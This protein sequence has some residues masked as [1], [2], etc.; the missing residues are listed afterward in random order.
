MFA[1]KSLIISFIVGSLTLSAQVGH[2]Q[3]ASKITPDQY[4]AWNISIFADGKNLPQGEGS[5]EEGA[6]LFAQECASCHGN[7]GHGGIKLDPYRNPI[8]TLVNDSS[9]G[10]LKASK[11]QKNIGT[12]WQYAPLLFDYIRRTM[13]YQSPKSLTDD[14]VYALSA[15]L[16]TQNKIITKTTRINNKN[17]A[18]VQM[19]NV[20]GFICD[21]H[22]DTVGSTCMKDCP[23]PNDA[24][25]NKNLIVDEKDYL[26]KDCLI[27]PKLKFLGL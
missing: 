2:Y 7:E 23:L 12:Y 13:P 11:P 16:L 15:Y 3:L 18:K 19:P 20:D 26:K 6:K 5:Y 1:S 14:E 25:F 4:K 21:N 24:T 22:V 8:A 10:G 17:L 27:Q 9:K